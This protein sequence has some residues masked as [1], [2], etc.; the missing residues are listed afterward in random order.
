MPR[1]GGCPDVDPQLARNG[2][3]HAGLRSAAREPPPALIRR[4]L[5]RQLGP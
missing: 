3:P 5:L 2:A 4:K 1:N